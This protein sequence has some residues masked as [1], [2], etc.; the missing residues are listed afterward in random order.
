LLLAAYFWLII[1]GLLMIIEFNSLYT[2]DAM[3]HAFFLGFTFSMIFAHAPIIFPG[4]A[5]LAI[6]PFHG[7]LF[8]WAVL[9]QVTLAMR[10]TADLLMESDIRKLSGM[11]TAAVILF[12]FINLVFIIIS[13]QRKTT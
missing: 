8:T 4:V 12:F 2:Y 10:V 11:L 9:L 13:K 6:R 3:L 7:S 1:C 5:G